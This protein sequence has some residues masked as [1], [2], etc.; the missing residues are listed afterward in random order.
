MSLE[1]ILLPLV[2]TLSAVLSLGIVWAAKKWS[3][4][5][6][7]KVGNEYVAGV[8]KRLGD[9]AAMVAKDLQQ[10]V[11]DKLKADEKWTTKTAQDVKAMAME[12][13]RLYMGTAGLAELVKVLGLE[14]EAL[15]KLLSSAIEAAVKDLRPSLP[16][17][18]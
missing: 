13:L 3:L 1:S 11:V 9:L 7:T 16:A 2:L 5:V 17:E 12:R 14:G 18:A 10:S 15:E 8:L 6:D 4:F